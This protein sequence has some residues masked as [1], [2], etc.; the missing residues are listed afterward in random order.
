[1][2]M[3]PFCWFHILGNICVGQRLRRVMMLSLCYYDVI[4]DN[5]VQL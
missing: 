4:Y 1:M 5:V 2:Y 3:F